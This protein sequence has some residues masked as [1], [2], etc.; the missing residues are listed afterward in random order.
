M[1]LF[2]KFSFRSPVLC[3][4]AIVLALIS[5]G[6]SSGEDGGTGGGGGAGPDPSEY[7]I[8]YAS[9]EER[10]IKTVTLQCELPDGVAEMCDWVIAVNHLIVMFDG[11]LGFEE[12]RRL[13]DA[14]VSAISSAGIPAER[15]GQIPLVNL[16][17]IEI[18]NELPDAA[19]ALGRLQQAEAI[20]EAAEG[21]YS[22]AY[23]FL[24]ELRHL[25]M[26]PSNDDNSR[27]PNEH[28]RGLAATDYYQA[29]PIFDDLLGPSNLNPVRVGIVDSGI[30]LSTRQFD[31]VTVRQATTPIDDIHPSGHGT[32]IAALIAADNGDGGLNGIASRILGDRLSLA[33][34]RVGDPGRL[35]DPAS[36]ASNF[37][38]LASIAHVLVERSDIV[39]LSLGYGR[40]FGSPQVTLPQFRS[41]RQQWESLLRDTGNVLYVVATSNRSGALSRHNDFPAGLDL[42]NVITV[43]AIDASHLYNRS[44]N[45]L[46]GPAHNVAAPATDVPVMAAGSTRIISARGTSYGTAMVTAMA[47]VMKSLNPAATPAQ[48][49]AFLSDPANGWPADPSAGDVRPS[50]LRTVGKYMIQ[51]GVSGATEVLDQLGGNNGDPDSTGLIMNRFTP[52]SVTDLAA[53]G[54]R[55]AMRRLT[56]ADTNFI[57]VPEPVINNA[58][59]LVVQIS[60]FSATADNYTLGVDS[61]APFALNTADAAATITLIIGSNRSPE[62]AGRTHVGRLVYTGCEITTRSL[63]T[64]WGT[65]GHA[66][67]DG[68]DARIFIQVEGEFT[69]TVEGA[70]FTTDPPTEPVTYEVAAQFNTAFRLL[71]TDAAVLDYLEQNC[72]G[73]FRYSP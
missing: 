51:Q 72:I 70:D 17:Q 56:G 8:E 32:N 25:P 57:S 46:S 68:P 45:T 69:G 10:Y 62:Y 20:V 38:T 44:E 6:C 59:G 35:D 28:R 47:A 14:A 52:Q 15:V 30:D 60:V 67:A 7:P 24:G 13:A 31:D 2:S 49:K 26:E 39:N 34:G 66:S 11:E 53:F 48:I 4:P 63:P 54:P 19:Q 37:E 61:S 23:D 27:F 5:S 64:N 22:V 21:V 33:V 18:E 36:F 12:A 65:L 1:L 40:Y 73:G 3:A 9:A 55:P 42:D 16:F 29:I 71:N 50:L 43:G 58:G 41:A